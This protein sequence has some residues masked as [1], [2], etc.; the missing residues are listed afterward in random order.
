[1][2]SGTERKAFF[3]G[4]TLDPGGSVVDAA[5][6]GRRFF[7]ALAFGKLRELRAGNSEDTWS[8][9]PLVPAAKGT[10]HLAGMDT[11][12]V[13]AEDQ[14]GLRFLPVRGAQACHEARPPVTGFLPWSARFVATKTPGS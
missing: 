10:L 4:R 7:V 11:W 2:A 13:V 5:F 3:G 8:D 6:V 1:M 12:L 9:V 14:S